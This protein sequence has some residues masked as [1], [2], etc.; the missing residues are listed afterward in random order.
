MAPVWKCLSTENLQSSDRYASVFSKQYSATT[1]V[2]SRRVPTIDTSALCMQ[3]AETMLLASAAGVWPTTRATAGSAW[4]KVMYRSCA[5]SASQ[6]R[7]R[8]AL[9]LGSLFIDVSFALISV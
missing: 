4:Q 2:P 8:V 7:K 3:S 6:R 9:G 1:Q 5:F